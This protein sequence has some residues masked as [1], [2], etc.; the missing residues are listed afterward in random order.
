MVF[1]KNESPQNTRTTSYQ[2]LSI[3]RS[4]VMSRSLVFFS[5]SQSWIFL[6]NGS[7]YRHFRQSSKSRFCLKVVWCLSIL[8]LLTNI[9][10][11]SCFSSMYDLAAFSRSNDKSTML[12]G[13]G[14][15][16]ELNYTDSTNVLVAN[17]KPLCATYT[18][19][20]LYSHI[21]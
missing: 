17:L 19:V 7:H 14:H 1:L 10:Y 2:D 16:D 8:V 15:K 4:F 11:T 18:R 5:V 12:L 20:H 9:L 21:T 3:S 13:C 6:H